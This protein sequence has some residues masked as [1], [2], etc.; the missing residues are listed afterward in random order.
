MFGFLKKRRRDSIRSRP[1]PSEWRD[2]LMRRY[3]M[4][5]R[6]PPADRR[7]LE[8]H[9]HVFLAEKRFEGCGGQEIT[10]EV[11]VLI[12]A[13]ACLLL[14]HRDTDCYPLLHSILVYPSSYIAKTWHWEKDGTITEG[15]QARGGESWPHGTVVLAWDGAIAGAV[16]L[17]KGRNLVLHEFAHQLDEEDG[18]ADGAPLLSGS[19]NLWQI[20]HRYQ[21]WA[22]V[23]SAE[24][25]QLRRAAEDGRETVLDTYGAQNPAEFF[26]VA[27]ECFFE[28][29][30][31]LKER[32]PALY[33]ELKEFYR[34][35]PMLYAPASPE[36]N[37]YPA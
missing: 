12:A 31:Q 11:R 27:T 3:S 8:G 5:S 33:A 17:S 14:L 28:K 26:A 2:I 13:Q 18:I 22:K 9:I 25:H 24:F 4:Y 6:L 36:K 20:H 35:D 30:G 21:T 19:T 23:L 15:E 32:H 7:E 1:F 16:E 10:D 34:Q 37:E 29:P